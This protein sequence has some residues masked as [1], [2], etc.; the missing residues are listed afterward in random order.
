MCVQNINNVLTNY[1]VVAQ[2]LMTRGSV[3]YLIVEI[4]SA[5][6][7]EIKAKIS[8]IEQNIKTRVLY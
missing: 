2:L 8:A 5:L 4:D 6:S 1:N 7:K 3:G